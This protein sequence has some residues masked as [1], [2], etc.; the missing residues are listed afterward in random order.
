VIAEGLSCQE[1]VELVTEYFDGAL[2]PQETLLFEQHAATCK[3]CGR[4]LDQM[5]R[6][7]EIAGQLTPESIPPEAEAALLDAFRDWK[8]R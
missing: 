1:L 8:S 2:S 3:G 7:I 5:R 4:Y 6:T